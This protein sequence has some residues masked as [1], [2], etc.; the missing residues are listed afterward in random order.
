MGRDTSDATACGSD[1]SGVAK[2]ATRRA[3]SG[4]S[5]ALPGLIEVNLYTEYILR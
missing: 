2:M 5:S 1:C 3:N 4:A